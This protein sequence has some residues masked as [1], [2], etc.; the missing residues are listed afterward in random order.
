MQGWPDK[1]Q[2][3]A[4][5]LHRHNFKDF[6]L[7]R[8]ENRLKDVKI[9]QNNIMAF[10]KGE[11]RPE[12][13]GRK[14]GSANKTTVKVREA[15]ELAFEGIGGVPALVEWAQKNQTEFY[16]LFAKLLPVQVE[17]SVDGKLDI[18]WQK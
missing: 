10:K 16:K 13:A 4:I 6:P 2:G 1:S 12:G 3:I 7:L 15:M 5:N 8:G 11:K 9:A 18:T 17:A 14:K